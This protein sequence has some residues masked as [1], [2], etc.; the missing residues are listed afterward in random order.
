M[1]VNRGVWRHRTWMGVL[2]LVLAFST[3]ACATLLALPTNNG[4]C[5]EPKEFARL[6]T[7]FWIGPEGARTPGGV[8]GGAFYAILAAPV[9]SLSY[10]VENQICH[11]S[12]GQSDQGQLYKLFTGPPEPGQR[13]PEGRLEAARQPLG[14]RQWEAL[15]QGRCPHWSACMTAYVDELRRGAAAVGYVLP[16]AEEKNVARLLQLAGDVDAG[17]LTR[18][19]TLVGI[20][21]RNQ[22]PRAIDEVP[23][24]EGLRMQLETAG[25]PS[26]TR[27]VA[28][29]EVE[30]RWRPAASVPED[31]ASM[32]RLRE[33]AREVHAGR[34][35][36]WDGLLATTSLVPTGTERLEDV[37]WRQLETDGCWSWV[38]CVELYGDERPRQAAGAALSRDDEATLQRYLAVARRGRGKDH[39][40]GGAPLAALL[41]LL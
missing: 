10:S 36:I 26:W 41:Q 18:G 19:A 38:R 20:P 34:L 21:G 31:D 23:L 12:K 4:A 11:S 30:R 29:Y 5:M 24:K 25:C 8:L 17:R 7:D 15:A 3:S 27:C 33:V 35:S 39:P 1:T 2:V 16:A 6:Y 40:G 28:F 13:S 14:A 22:P 9:A 32:G 37:L